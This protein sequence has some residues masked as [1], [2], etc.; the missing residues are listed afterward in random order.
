MSFASKVWEHEFGGDGGHL[1]GKMFY[2]LELFLFLF[3]LFEAKQT[4]NLIKSNSR[5]SF[6]K[7]EIP[8]IKF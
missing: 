5:C 2:F 3:V 4:K 7:K 1:S 6:S 8:K